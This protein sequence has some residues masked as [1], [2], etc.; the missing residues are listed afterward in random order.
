MNQLSSL[1]STSMH[2]LSIGVFWICYATVSYN[3]FWP[4]LDRH[5]EAKLGSSSGSDG[6][7]D[8]DN[9]LAKNQDRTISKY[10]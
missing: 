1:V 5:D 2:G 8:I 3:G 9:A 10:T 4:I 6:I 7:Y